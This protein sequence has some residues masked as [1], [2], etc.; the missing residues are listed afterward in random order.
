MFRLK[1]QES[2]GMRVDFERLAEEYQGFQ[3]V[4]GFEEVEEGEEERERPERNSEQ[5]RVFLIDPVTSLKIKIAYLLERA[6]RPFLV[7]LTT[8]LEVIFNYV[9][10]AV[11]AFFFYQFARNDLLSFTSCVTFFLLSM[12]FIKLLRDLQKHK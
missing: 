1:E 7:A 2:E 11:N 8:F 12:G 3:G 6:V 4:Q 5:G 9:V 10:F